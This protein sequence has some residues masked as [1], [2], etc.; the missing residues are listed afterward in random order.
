MNQ[1]SFPTIIL[2]GEGALAELSNR[3]AV[4][5]LMLANRIQSDLEVRAIRKQLYEKT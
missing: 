1:F 2:H 4:K 3:I 5:K